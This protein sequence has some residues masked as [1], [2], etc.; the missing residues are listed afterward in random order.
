[1]KR[2]KQKADVVLVKVDILL[3]LALGLLRATD[4]AVELNDEIMMT[5]N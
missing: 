1:M 2:R 5:L 4:V 3:D